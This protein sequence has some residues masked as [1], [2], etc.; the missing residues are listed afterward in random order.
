MKANI[1]SKLLLIV[2]VVCSLSVGTATLWSQQNTSNEVLVYV[3]L[4]T[5]DVPLEQAS[6]IELTSASIKSPAFLTVL[7]RFQIS[8]MKRAFA[9]FNLA[10]TL[11]YTADGKPIAMLNLARLYK[12]TVPPPYERDS[13]IVAL[14]RLPDVIY[15]EKNGGWKLHTNDPHYTKQWYLKNTGQSGGTAGADIKAEDAWQIFTGSSQIKIGIIDSGIKTNHEDLSG[16]VTGDNPDYNWHDQY[17]YNSYSHGTHVAGI[18]SAKTSNSIGIAGVDQNAQIYS[19]RIFDSQNHQNDNTFIYNVIVD[20]VNQ[21]CNVLNNSWGGPDYSTTIRGAFAYAYKM[22]RVAI[23]SMGNSNGSQTQYPAGF[24]QGIIA[25]GSTQDNDVVSS[26]SDIGNHIDVSAPGGSGTGDIHDIFS[27]VAYSTSYGYYDFLGGTSMAAPVV[28]GIASLLKGYNSNLYNDDIEHIIQ[29]SADKVR[30]DLYTYDANGWNV[31][32][33][34]GRVNAKKALDMLRSPY[35]LTQATTSS[36]T[37]VGSTDYYTMLIL[38]APGLSD[39]YYTVKRHDVQH[40]VSFS[41]MN[42]AHV[43]GRGVSSTGWSSDQINYALGW[44]DAVPGTVTS[45]SA[46]L[47]TYVYEVWTILGQW[48]G[49][50]PTTPQNVAY[51]YTVFG[52]PI[53]LGV[54]GLSGPD[55]LQFKQQ[56]TWHPVI[57]SGSGSYSY[58]WYVSTDNGSTWTTLGTAYTQSRT[59]V[60]SDFIM[61]CDV[62]DNGTG[63]NASARMTIYY[64]TPPPK[65]GNGE[66]EIVALAQEIPT[67]Y[68]LAQN[69][70]NPFNPST[71]IR[72]ALPEQ[73]HVKLVIYDMLGRE[74]AQLVDDQMEAGF[75]SVTWNAGTLSSGMYI[76]R[77]VAGSFVQ[78]KKLTLTK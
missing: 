43:W 10:D 76:C 29:L 69:Y 15:A 37:D 19:R 28:T 66:E 47:R 24:G 52:Q 45:T 51:A 71:E 14:S 35:V 22:N 25:I 38:G 6:A 23:C 50:Y 67:E 9:N 49:W 56:G 21:G 78:T 72:F 39:A 11:R 3:K 60:Y 59:M 77:L 48:V 17:W 7:Q 30:P 20:A 54:E 57:I 73:A 8:K 26:F 44:C 16:K 4:N 70:P 31:N 46:V 65:V 5:I 32:V 34:Y 1:F 75:H 53:H 64:G 12:L 41:P 62:H 63:E 2:A 58:Q 61:R 18:A 36:G 55:F 27:T 33:G 40:T 42:G 13:V 74:V 68:S